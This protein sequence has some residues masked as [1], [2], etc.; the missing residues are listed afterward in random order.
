VETFTG[1]TLVLMRAKGEEL[2]HSLLNSLATLSTDEAHNRLAHFLE[3][4]DQGFP[5]QADEGATTHLSPMQQ[6]TTTY[7][8]LQFE[9]VRLAVDIGQVK[10][11]RKVGDAIKND[12]FLRATHIL[13]G[14]THLE[15]SSDEYGWSWYFQR[16]PPFHAAAAVLCHL[17][18]RPQHFSDTAKLDAWRETERFF[19]RHAL[20]LEDGFGEES[21]AW[22][23]LRTWRQHAMVNFGD[24][25]AGCT[26]GSRSPDWCCYHIWPGVLARRYYGG[27]RRVAGYN[28]LVNIM[29][30]S[31]GMSLHLKAIIRILTQYERPENNSMESS[32][33][34]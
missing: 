24:I 18:H 10:Y 13:C 17:M 30:T 33:G 32:L 23:V 1:M 22:D 16:S 25:F 9:Q 8:R 6:L 19:S 3:E 31:Q 14:I 2:K 7:I 34:Q 11:G 21:K 27:R 15:R 26:I 4:I 20:V 28:T 12:I 5:S 29:I